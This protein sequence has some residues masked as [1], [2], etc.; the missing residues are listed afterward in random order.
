[1]IRVGTTSNQ[2]YYPVWLPSVESTQHILSNCISRDPTYL[3]LKH[4]KIKN[5]EI[6]MFLT[7]KMD[8]FQM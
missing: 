8:H 6:F 2:L 5:D 4:C 3:S 7:L 1:M